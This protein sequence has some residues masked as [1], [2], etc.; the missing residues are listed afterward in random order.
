MY[1]IGLLMSESEIVLVPTP[2]KAL[3]ILVF[4]A[5]LGFAS[6]ILKYKHTGAVRTLIHYFISAVAFVLQ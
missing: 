5:V 4:S 6:L 2:S 3:L 1:I